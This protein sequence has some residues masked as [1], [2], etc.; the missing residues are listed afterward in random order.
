MQAQLDD[1]EDLL[2]A[3][4]GSTETLMRHSDALAAEI[5]LSHASPPRAAGP[6]DVSGDMSGE[7][8]AEG[9][10]IRSCGGGGAAGGRARE[11][12]ALAAAAAAATG[13][14]P[15]S[16]DGGEGAGGSNGSEGVSGGTGINRA[17]ANNVVNVAADDYSYPAAKRELSRA[18]TRLKHNASAAAGKEGGASLRLSAAAAELPAEAVSV[19]LRPVEVKVGN[20]VTPRPYFADANELFT[21]ADAEE[22]LNNAKRSGRS[23]GSSNRSGSSS[24]SSSSSSSRIS[25]SLSP[26]PPAAGA[27]PSGSVNADRRRRHQDAA[28]SRQYLQLIVSKDEEQRSLNNKGALSPLVAVFGGCGGGRS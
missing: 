1:L 15:L 26:P 9:S 16:V 10:G 3:V 19:I 11:L 5:E 22:M 4:T 13:A 20:V 21:D 23:N 2:K 27:S 7:A 12:G 14:V 17:A 28:E 6:V 24:S 8:T 18:R 25:R